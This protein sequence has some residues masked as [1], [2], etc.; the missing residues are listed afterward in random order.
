VLQ[1]GIAQDLFD[2]RQVV[3]GPGGSRAPSLCGPR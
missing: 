1:A 3:L 2:Q